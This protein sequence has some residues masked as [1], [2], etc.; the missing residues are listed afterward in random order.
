MKHPIYPAN[1]EIYKYLH[2]LYDSR[3][4]ALTISIVGGGGKT[5]L[6][7]WLASLFKLHG[8]RVCITTTTKMYLPDDARLDHIVAL[9]NDHTAFN[10][11]QLAQRLWQE[12]PLDH[13]P[14]ITFL[15]KSILPA[16]SADEADKVQGLTYKQ[17]DSYRQAGLFTVFIVEADGAKQLPIKAPSRHEPCIVTDSDV[18]I[19]VTGAEAILSSA[20]PD[21]IHRWSEFA[22]ITQCEP[23]AVIDQ[24]VLQRLITNPDG[25]FKGSPPNARRIWVI[26]KCDL[27]PNQEALLKLAEQ[28]TNQIPELSSVWL[29][30]FHAP[31]PIQCVFLNGSL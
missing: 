2:D 15:Y 5:H 27:S 6:A 30:S 19:G 20:Q 1:R 22:T 16:S 4:A 29:T 3:H 24:S 18:V 8:H 10:T 7:F 14:A 11:R 26:N 25:M 23:Q 28:L 31:S 9:D 21:R 17:L 13:A 12:N